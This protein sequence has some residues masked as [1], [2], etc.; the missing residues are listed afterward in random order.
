MDHNEA[1]TTRATEK[2]LLNELEPDLRNQFEEHVFDCN[3]CAL[4]LRVATMLVENSK[5]ILGQPRPLREPV[6]SPNWGWMQWLRP[7]VTIPV[8][9][10]LLAVIGYQATNRSRDFASGP[11]LINSLSLIA[12]NA[13]GGSSNAATAPSGKPFVMY[14]DVPPVAQATSFAADFHNPDGG[15]LWTLPITGDAAKDT[16]TIQVPAVSGPAGTY[17]LMIRSI[18][19]VGQSTEVARYPVAIG[20]R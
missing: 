19:G 3:E 6:P 17:I 9:A 12:A 14:V 7:A 2:Y 4:D 10:T 15:L 8:M 13:R 20:L 5:I 1:T 11:Q 16:L 18:N